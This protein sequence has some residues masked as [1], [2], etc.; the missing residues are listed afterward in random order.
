MT[1]STVYYKGD[2]VQVTSAG[3]Y[4]H[5]TMYPLRT[6]GSVEVKQ[7]QKHPVQNEEAIRA[8]WPVCAG[9]FG[10]ILLYG[11]GQ[12]ISETVGQV[13]AVAAATAGLIGTFYL[14]A[15][16]PPYPPEYSVIVTGPDGKG[17][18]YRHADRNVIQAIAS[19]I[20][21]ALAAR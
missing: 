17:H 12:Y 15:M 1:D 14:Y 16:T 20:E 7:H 11:L 21:T 3:V 6:I 18:F 13:L 10:G 5:G 2:G 9:V 8:A 19:A 4:F